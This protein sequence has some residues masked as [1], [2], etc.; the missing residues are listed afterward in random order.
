MTDP[1]FGDGAFSTAKFALDGLAKRQELIGRNVSNVD[2][3][4]YRAVDLNFESALQT[5]INKTDAS[6]DAIRNKLDGISSS[7]A[8]AGQKLGQ[9]IDT[10]SPSLARLTQ[11]IDVL[12]KKLNEVGTTALGAGA[13]LTGIGAGLVAPLAMAVKTAMTMSRTQ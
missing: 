12:S 5:A 10:S 13:A 8:G 7:A 3:P 9:G 2:T 6:F 11:N 4:G 1:I